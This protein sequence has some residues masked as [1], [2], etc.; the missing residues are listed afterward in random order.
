MIVPST[1]VLNPVY[2]LNRM[3]TVLS[4]SREATSPTSALHHVF[5]NSSLSY[6]SIIRLHMDNANVYRCVPN[7]LLKLALLNKSANNSIQWM[8]LTDSVE[9]SLPNDVIF[10]L[11]LSYV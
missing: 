3:K 11:L 6:A 9:G 8:L 5:S 2:Y 1:T 4:S 7:V 10:D